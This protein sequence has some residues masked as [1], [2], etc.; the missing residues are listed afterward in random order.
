[1]KDSL[2]S[3]LRLIVGGY[4][5]ISALWIAFSD[6][7]VTHFSNDRAVVQT[8]NT[9]KGWLFVVT[10]ALLLY[11]ALRRRDRTLEERQASLQAGAE[12]LKAIYNT[13][14]EAIFV[15]DAETGR[16][17]DCNQRACEIF[18]YAHERFIGMSIGELSE[19]RADYSQSRATE[20]LNK[21]IAQG[22][23]LFEWRARRADGGCFWAEVSLGASAV[24][25]Q[26]Y[27]VAAVRDITDRKRS[28]EALRGSEERFET[29][30]RLSPNA[31]LISR[32]S[33]GLCLK[34]NDRFLSLTGYTLDE[35]VGQ[36]ALEGGLNFWVDPSLRQRM[37]RELAERQIVRGVEGDVRRKNGTIVRV[38]LS[39]SVFVIGQETCVIS[40]VVDITA[41]QAMEE[42]MRRAQR[43]ESLG[44]LAGGIAHDFNNLLAGVFGHLELAKEA[45]RD[46][47]VKEAEENMLDALSVSGRARALTQQLLTFAKGGAPL[48]K[49]QA[50]GEL[51]RKS[52]TFATTGSNCQVSFDF[53]KT[54]W[55]SSLDE[56]QMGQVI[57]NLIINAK[58]AMPD[59]GRIEV[60]I[61]NVPSS[62]VPAHLPAVD[63][64]HVSIRDHG[65]GIPREHLQRIFDPF[66]STKAQGSGLGLATSYSI[67][68][69]HDGHIEAE[70][71]VGVGSVFQIWLPRATSESAGPEAST[72]EGD[73]GHG[74]V[75]VMDDEDFVLDV[76]SSML[77]RC[78]YQAIRAKNSQQAVDLASAALTAGRPFRAAILDITIPGGVGGKETVHRLKRLDPAIRVLVSSGYAG[79]DVLA[80]PRE[81]GFDGSLPKPYQLRDLRLAMSHLF[82][83]DPS[84]LPLDRPAP[85]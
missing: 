13:V 77:R 56:N 34:A 14:N 8:L 1:M 2:R 42:V 39:S 18:G 23:Q 81:F 4:V 72:V 10:T 35:I 59:G 44:V 49:V 6:H 17:L 25:G 66:F 47:A 55:L 28:E 33:D 26:R 15:H 74:Q 38:L 51:V 63:H 57:D 48:R 46:H 30:F 61:R 29:M 83:P 16:I 21:T 78:G 64:V 73:G 62:A 5:A 7:L 70:S 75:L 45:L 79:D 32:L 71:E 41:K 80:R 24:G 65:V 36:S 54:E 84:P 20:W 60:R 76:A 68:R 19:E 58:Q 85:S 40:A 67:V 52:V 43:L 37:A 9:C 82:S 50:V 22:A 3:K 27:V 69:K 12:Q 31:L 11:G 53:E